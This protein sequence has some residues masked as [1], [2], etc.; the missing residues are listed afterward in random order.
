MPRELKAI[1]SDKYNLMKDFGIKMSRKEVEK[2][3]LDAID[4][5]P[6]RDMQTVVDAAFRPYVREAISNN[7]W[8][9]C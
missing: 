4:S 3:V 1:V 8:R 9:Q 5:N 6:E 7:S 2:I